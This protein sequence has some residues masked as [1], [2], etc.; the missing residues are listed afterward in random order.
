MTNTKNTKRALLTSVLALFL[1]FT[2]LLGT[3]FAWF[4]DSVTSANNVITS[5]NLDVVLEYKSNWNDEWTPVTAETLLFNDQALY[6]PGYTEIV[7]LRVSNA[8]SL[9]LK[10]NLM[11]NL[12]NETAGINVYGDEFKLSDYL[13]FGSYRMD[14]YDGDANYADI[15]MPIM[16]GSRESALTNASMTT[17]SEANP[18]LVENAPVL[19]GENTAQVFALVLSMPESVGNEA[20]AVDKDNVPSIDFGINVL[21][22]QFT[23]ENDSFGNDYDADA[24]YMNK[25]ADGEWEI[26]SVGQLLYFAQSVNSGASFYEGET[27]VL[28]SDIDLKGINWAPIGSMTAD[29]GFMGNFDGQGHTIKNLTIVNPTVDEDGYAYAGFFGLTEGTDKDNQNFVKNLV[30]ENVTISTEGNIAAAAIAYAYYTTVEDITV[31]GDIAIEGGDYTAGA[32]AY[33]RRCV[34]AKNI[35]VSGN[36]GSY[37][38]G[39]MTVGGVISDIQMNGGLTANYANFAA[40]N[41]TI[42]GEKSVGG[43]SGIICNQTLNGATVTDVTLVCNDPCT[44]IVAGAT[45]GNYS[46]NDATYTNV[47][48]ATELVGAPWG[49]ESNG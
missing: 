41:L 31:C 21:A 2:M 42:T 5:G 34:D 38:T 15:L 11:F 26:G 46:L 9:A 45:S 36:D 32:L 7:F 6:E 47:T 25:N 10:Y 8:G 40:Y 14:E 37:I 27:V 20:N 28:T 35:T 30:I 19:V 1:C 24:T 39:G 49:T 33:T 44:G 48:G 12:K 43:I 23:K 29:H 17:L 3:T 22:T 16:F 4:T 18:M 13:E